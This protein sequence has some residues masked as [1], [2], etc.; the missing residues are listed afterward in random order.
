MNTEKSYGL[1]V[2]S[3]LCPKIEIPLCELPGKSCAV[4]HYLMEV[5]SKIV[6]R[7]RARLLLL[8][9]ATP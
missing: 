8:R 4:K 7:A 1:R 6:D 9:F 2:S 5:V 3:E